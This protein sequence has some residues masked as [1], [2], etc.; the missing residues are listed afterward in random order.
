LWNWK[1]LFSF[2]F[3]RGGG[4][5]GDPAYMMLTILTI[6]YHDLRPS[7]FEGSAIHTPF[8][9]CKVLV[10][11]EIPSL[12]LCDLW[13]F[14]PHILLDFI[15]FLLSCTT[16]HHSRYLLC[17]TYYAHDLL[18]IFF[19]FCLPTRLNVLLCSAYVYVLMIYDVSSLH[20][21]HHTIPS[22][23]KTRAHHIWCT[24]GTLSCWCMHEYSMYTLLQG[25]LGFSGLLAARSLK[26]L[27]ICP[28]FITVRNKTPARFE[29]RSLSSHNPLLVAVSKFNG[30]V[31]NPQLVHRAI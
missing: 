11:T 24:C 21:Y 10:F 25:F 29:K 2:S 8:R 3:G 30:E 7:A 28:G 20:I 19:T 4:R 22:L 27:R 16:T 23:S 15:S 12:L 31:R 5:E 9:S 13:F 1:C 6:T 18:D 17:T 14:S 26:S